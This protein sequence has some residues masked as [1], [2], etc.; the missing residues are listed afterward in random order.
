MKLDLDLLVTRLIEEKE[1][2]VLPPNHCNEYLMTHVFL[3][4][5]RGDPVPFGAIDYDA[6]DETDIWGLAEYNESVY[7]LIRA[8]EQVTEKM[9][10]IKPI[11]HPVRQFC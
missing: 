4:L 3:P 5:L 6:F 11:A 8:L 10:D 2:P 7:R 9:A 1:G